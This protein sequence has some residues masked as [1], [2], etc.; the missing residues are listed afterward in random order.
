M[1][2][3]IALR[4]GYVRPDDLPRG[5]CIMTSLFAEDGTQ[6]GIRIAEWPD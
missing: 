5:E 2:A 3:E 4:D 6:T 1:Y